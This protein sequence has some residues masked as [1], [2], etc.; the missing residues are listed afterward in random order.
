M[1]IRD[2]L[3]IFLPTGL[4]LPK[5]LEDRETVVGLFDRG[6]VIDHMSV[7]RCMSDRVGAWLALPM[8]T[9]LIVEATLRAT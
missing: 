9:R 1:C 8:D 6:R 5:G 7:N 3:P 4:S 2:R